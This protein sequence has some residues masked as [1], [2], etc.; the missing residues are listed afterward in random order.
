MIVLTIKRY[1]PSLFPDLTMAFSS[2]RAFRPLG[3]WLFRNS[4]GLNVG[5]LP[6]IACS[7]SL[8]RW[9][10]SI[11]TSS[12]LMT[13]FLAVSPSTIAASGNVPCF[14]HR[15]KQ[16]I[17]KCSIK[18]VDK[19]RVTT[20]KWPNWH[21]RRLP[22]LS[23]GGR[24]N[25]WN[26]SFVINRL[27]LAISLKT[28]FLFHFLSNVASLNPSFAKATNNSVRCDKNRKGLELLQMFLKMFI[29]HFVR[30]C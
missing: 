21:F 10:F 6:S 7:C 16:E 17:R 9:T 25:A 8:L 4:K 22:F 11:R 27:T 1:F 15:R 26:A 20:I 12:V 18:R 13:L 14:L 19:G 2:L 30:F 23:L 24:A 29:L 5:T 28:K 3:F